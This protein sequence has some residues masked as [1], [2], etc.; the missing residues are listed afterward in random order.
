MEEEWLILKLALK[1]NHIIERELRRM[2]FWKKVELLRNWHVQE[3]L[4]PWVVL[5]FLTL[6]KESSRHIL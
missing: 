5:S 4:S 6:K 1:I 2:G 3:S